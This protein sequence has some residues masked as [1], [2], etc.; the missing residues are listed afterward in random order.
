MRI[1]LAQTGLLIA[2]LIAVIMPL[3]NC[4]THDQE[5]VQKNDAVHVIEPMIRLL[6]AS[7]ANRADTP[8]A[9]AMDIEEIW[10]IEDTRQ[11]SESPLVVGMRNGEHVLGYDEPSQTFYCTIGLDFPDDAWPELELYVQ[12]A[13]DETPVNAVFVDDY[14]YDYPAD[15]VADGY[16]Y[17]LIAYT[18]TQYAYIG[19]VFTGLPIVT[20]DIFYDGEVEEQYVP[21][22]VSV[23]GAGYEAID[24]A[25]LTHMRG[26]GV[27]KGIDKFSYRIQFHDEMGRGS[28]KTKDLSVLGM[29]ADSDWL[30]ICNAQE[31]TA[32]R[33]YL[34]YEMWKMWH[35]DEPA[36]MKLESELVELFVDDEYMGIYQLMERV[37]AQEEILGMG[38]DLQ[39]DSAVRLVIASNRGEKPSK[40]YGTR[41]SFFAEYRYGPG[42][43]A[44]AVF[45]RFDAY[46]R[47]NE[48]VEDRPDDEE[49]AELAQKYVDLDSA[50]NYYLFMQACGLSDNVINNLYVWMMEEEGRMVYKFSPWDMDYC[51]LET[52]F[53]EDGS[54]V[55][56]FEEKMVFVHRML[57]LNLMN[58]RERL[59]EIWQE[60]RKTILSDAAVWD[61]IM[62]MQTYLNAS[63]AYRRESNK[64]RG[65]AYQ[66]NM[67]PML[68]FEL[69][70]LWT[71]ESTL[72]QRWPLED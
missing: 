50:L 58:S 4:L 1:K 61:W 44:D 68:D 27:Y 71:V 9:P 26:G 32:A 65:G 54:V 64:W 39:T 15:S 17:E 59:W 12:G 31:E 42:E 57:D 28:K 38:G 29:E 72:A 70:H 10:A 34:A 60:K 37:D 56:Y 30:L 13:D 19:V 23:A 67:T 47:M 66:V 52:G 7:A 22:H 35:A 5:N 62:D 45:E 16:R 55:P 24:T 6:N 69:E 49:F 63:G 51:L 25:A 8:L 20:M 43:D 14:T 2:L 18:D 36:P 3:A 41:S 21:A 33:N 46:A 11:E 53:Q 40:S 48:I